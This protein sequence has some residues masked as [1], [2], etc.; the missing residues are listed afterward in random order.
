MSSPAPELVTAPAPLSASG[1]C[2]RADMVHS[3]HRDASWWIE[4]G[5][6]TLYSNIYIYIYI[7]VCVYIFYMYLSCMVIGIGIGSDTG[8]V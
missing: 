7:Y 8:I 1:A 4:A 3:S 5:G 6:G 2:Q